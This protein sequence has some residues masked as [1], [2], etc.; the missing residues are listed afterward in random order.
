M[1]ARSAVLLSVVSLAF[2]A[3]V[4]AGVTFYDN[5][6]SFNAVVTTSLIDDYEGGTHDALLASLTQNGVTYTP[7]DGAPFPNVYLISSGATNFGLGVG[8]TA[9]SVLVANGDENFRAD[10]ATPVRAVGFDAYWNGLGPAVITVYNGATVLGTYSPAGNPDNKGFLGFITD[11]AAITGFRWDTT[12]G[13]RLNTGI[14][15]LSTAPIP[16]PETYAMLLAGLGLLGF[17]ARRRQ[18]QAA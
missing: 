3:P 11:G 13:G 5:Q 10:F 6:A 18:Q 7:T 12:L 1:E 9:T 8:T 15:N 17:A 14:D 16:E 2:A 4:S